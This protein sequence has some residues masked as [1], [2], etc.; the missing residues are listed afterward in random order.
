M[1]ELTLVR[2]AST[3]LTEAGR[4]QGHSDAVLSA[5]GR[6]EAQRLGNHL[7]DRRFDLVVASDLRRCVE[8]LSI[9][10]PNGLWRLGRALLG[11]MHGYTPGPH[12]R[13]DSEPCRDGTTRRRNLRPL[14]YSDH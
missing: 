10:L 13:V 4:Y 2:H 3:P 11:G 6:T 8:T 9:A 12:G 7:A 5:R 1:L 14:H